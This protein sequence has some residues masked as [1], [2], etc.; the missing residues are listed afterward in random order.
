MGDPFARCDV[1]LF[2]A[3]TLAG[4]YALRIL[5][6]AVAVGMPLSLRMLLLPLFLFLSLAFVKRLAELDALRRQQH[7]QAA[8]RG[9]DVEELPVLQR[10][11]SAAGHLI[12]G[13]PALCVG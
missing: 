3:L 4:L 6:A 10:L 12:V 5:A 1:L 8:G 9:Y 11:G 13:A 2:Y 7:L